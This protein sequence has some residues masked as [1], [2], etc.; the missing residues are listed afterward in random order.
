MDI[1]NE[2]LQKIDEEL[3]LLRINIANG[4]AD[5]FANYKQFVGRIQG[6][7]WSK[8]V[9]TSIMKKIYVGEEE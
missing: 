9:I 6:I 4:Q 8:E 3:N 5:N 1:Y 7:E 2:V